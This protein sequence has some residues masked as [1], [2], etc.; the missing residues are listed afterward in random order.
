LVDRYQMSLQSCLDQYLTKYKFANN[1]SEFSMVEP[2]LFQIYKPE[3]GFK[4]WH[5]EQSGKSDVT[6]HLVFMTYLNTI[7]EDDFG[8]GT[9]FYYQNKKVKAI[10][11]RTVIWPVAFTHTHRGIVSK[12]S[13]KFILT[14][15][16]S[17]T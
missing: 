11:G 6:R 10:A 8:G 15:W 3:G 5:C 16:F 9:A 2:Y 7:E 4:L 13:D 12:T 1:V 14:G 17:F